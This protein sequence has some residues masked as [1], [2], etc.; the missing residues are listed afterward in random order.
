MFIRHFFE[1]PYLSLFDSRMT[2]GVESK[3][4][5]KG[6]QITDPIE[7]ALG[8]YALP[9]ASSRTKSASLGADCYKVPS[10]G[11]K[12]KPGCI[13]FIPRCTF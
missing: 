2:L 1:K 7:N 8:D 12:C 4:F 10:L 3:P 9:N 13:K 11:Q 6:G 5:G